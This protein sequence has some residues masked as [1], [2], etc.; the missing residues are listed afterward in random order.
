MCA[1]GLATGHLFSPQVESNFGSY[2]RF[3]MQAFTYLG[4]PHTTLKLAAMKFI[5]RH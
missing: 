3:L 1:S 4:S 2:Q 5:G